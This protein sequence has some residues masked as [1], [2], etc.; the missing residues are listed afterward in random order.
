MG[1]LYITTDH[2]KQSSIGQNSHSNSRSNFGQPTNFWEVHHCSMF[3]PFVHN[4][5]HCDSVESQSFRKGFRN[6]TRLTDIH[7]ILLHLFLNFFL[8]MI[9]SFS[10]SFG[11]LDFVSQLSFNWFLDW[12]QVRQLSC[13]G[14][15]RRIGGCDKPNYVLNEGHNHFVKHGHEFLDFY[16]LNNNIHLKTAFCVYLCSFWLTFNSA[17]WC[18]TF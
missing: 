6:F 9:S 13:Q 3:L 14:V 2:T 12:E 7:Y 5:Y 18:E 4:G 8:S 16:S 11:P 17:W 10:R 15:P 1:E